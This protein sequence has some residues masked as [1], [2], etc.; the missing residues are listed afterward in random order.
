MNHKGLKGEALVKEFLKGRYSERANK[1]YDKAFY[2]RFISENGDFKHLKEVIGKPAIAYGYSGASAGTGSSDNY[3]DYFLDNA[4]EIPEELMYGSESAGKD[5]SSSSS[6]T[7]PTTMNKY[8]YFSQV[9]PRWNKSGI[10]GTTVAKAGCGPTSHAMMLTTM[11]GKQINPYTMAKFGLNKGAWS[12]SGMGWNMPTTVAK[13]FGLKITNTWQGKSA[14]VLSSIKEQL[15]SGHPVV[16]SGR[17]SGSNRSYSTPFTPG[18][19]IVLA[20]GVDGSGNIIINDPRA[21][22]R[23][24]AYTDAGLREGVGLRGAWAFA[25]TGS[26]SIPSGFT[27]DGDYVPGADV[28]IDGAVDGTATAQAETPEML[29]VFSKMNQIVQNYVGSIF[30]GKDVD[31]FASSN[32]SSTDTTTN[33]TGTGDFPKYNLNDNQ[34]KG[35]AAIIQTE[36]PGYD[37]C[38]AEASLLANLTDI[39]GD[40]KA[41]PENIIAKA[42][43]GWFGQ[44]A[45]KAFNSPNTAKQIAIDAVKSVIVGGRRTLPRYVNE[46][47]CFSDIKSATNNGSA[48]KISDRSAYKQHVTKIKNVYGA[49]GTFYGFPNSQADPFFYTS[50][51]YRKKWG[52]NCYEPLSAG[53]GN[54]L[55][56]MSGSA[57][58]G[59]GDG[60]VHLIAPTTDNK[61]KPTTSAEVKASA[62][63]GKIKVG[64]GS[65][66]IEKLKKVSN[67]LLNT[68]KLKNITRAT[69]TESVNYVDNSNVAICLDGMAEVLS[70]LKEININTA[71][72]AE[73]ISKIQI[74]SA[75][76][77]VSKYTNQN[78]NTSK[79]I[80]NN[81]AR[82]G[83]ITNT[84]DYTTA[85]RLA[86]FS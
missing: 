86:S 14:S 57:G 15:K 71:N 64:L 6:S 48:I 58:K 83:S 68:G 41:T 28:A 75:N 44:R 25:K 56:K 21:A 24:K 27:V 18:G 31:L 36:Q 61:A 19:H 12:S 80:S 13:S 17:T 20:V 54:N 51:T 82:A 29:G 30:N 55:S 3:N 5:T 33:A 79:K 22:N 4:D 77:P 34:I 63:M 39:S 7:Y 72:T 47:D 26:S 43:G 45:K 8:A 1:N 76:E 62:K 70:E 2:N 9:D 10:G 49:T 74:Y 67:N 84:K 40:D 60:K 85:R 37:G 38:Q 11:F 59:D 73:N 81:K 69:K 65:G 16:M 50:D 53:S 66:T 32:S 46:H 42:T 78:N 23:S 35:L 52:E